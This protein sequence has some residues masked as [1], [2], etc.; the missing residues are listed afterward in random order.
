MDK[1]KNNSR[2]QQTEKLLEQCEQD[3]KKLEAF[4]K[5]FKSIE[6]NRTALE[7]Y[8]KVRYQKDYEKYPESE[9][10]YRLLDQDSIWNVLS[11]QYE[12]KIKIL[13]AITNS[14]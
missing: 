6:A 2:L 8:Y 4:Q 7:D 12:Q 3:L 9:A 14:I 5:E 13:K 10:K 1:I 11:D